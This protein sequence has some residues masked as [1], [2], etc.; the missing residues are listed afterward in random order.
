MS[1]V[2][3]FRLFICKFIYLLNTH[4][5]SEYILILVILFDSGAKHLQLGKNKNKIYS[6]TVIHLLRDTQREY[7]RY[8]YPNAFFS[9]SLCS[10]LYERFFESILITVLLKI[11]N[12]G[13]GGSL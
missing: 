1:G 12:K 7:V 6:L 5:I 8:T 11:A 3:I 4:C 13:E 9:S 2:P 10:S